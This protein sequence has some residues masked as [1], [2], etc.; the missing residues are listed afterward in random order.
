MAKRGRKP[1]K[2][3]VSKKRT[4]DKNIQVVVMIIISILLAALI[5]GK[6]GS[7]GKNLSPILGGIMGWIKFII[8]IGMFTISISYACDKRELLGSKVIELLIFVMCICTILSVY[9]ISNHNLNIKD[10][11][12][13]IISD[14][15]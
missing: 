3:T 14:S 9:Q 13:K 7:I 15:Y 1:N 10:G 11:M 8:P 2:R 12:S 6:T 4:S 5:Y